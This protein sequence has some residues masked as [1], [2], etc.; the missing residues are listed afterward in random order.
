MKQAFPFYDTQ[1]L[2]ELGITKQLDMIGRLTVA[3]IFKALL[4]DI[5]RSATVA[6]S[7]EP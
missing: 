7:R 5:R 1:Q 3:F 4:W 6:Q 2:I